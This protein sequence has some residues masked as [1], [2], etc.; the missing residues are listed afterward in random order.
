MI[1]FAPKTF[2]I[3][4]CVKYYSNNNHISKALELP[5]QLMGDIY[6]YHPNTI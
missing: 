6:I 2:D 3:K 1:R 4:I 5:E